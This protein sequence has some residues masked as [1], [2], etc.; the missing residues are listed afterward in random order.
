M[1]CYK[2]LT[3]NDRMKIEKMNDEGLKV[4]EIADRLRVHRSTIYREL[5]R[6]SCKQISTHLVELQKYCS[7]VAQKRYEANLA[8]KGVQIK[9][10]RHHDFALYLEKKIA[11]EKY[12]PAA[13]LASIKQNDL[14]F[15]VMICVRTLYNYIDHDVF[16]AI[17]NK[18]LPIKGKRKN[19]SYKRVKTQKRTIGESIEKRDKNIE[20]REE[21]GHFEMDTVKGTWASSYSLLVLTERKTRKEF[22][23]KIRHLAES[24]VEVLNDLER[25][26][27]DNF[28]KIFKTIT[29][30]NGTEFSYT[31]R[32]QTSILNPEEERTKLY[33]CHAYSSWERGS[34]ENANKLIRRHIEKGTDFDDISV[35]RVKYI[36]AWINQYP[37]AIFNYRCAEVL[38]QEELGKLGIKTK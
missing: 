13:A 25:Q 15:G 24:V 38:W 2:H 20:K 29:M 9:L 17:T 3:W 12:S 4:G 1:R 16:G 22:I 23:F 18:E 7:D 33:Y 10:A 28:G 6:G 35:E 34:N 5:K 11:E 32:L 19:K 8:S 30:D 27:G 31:K 37:R 26:W 21:F 14:D 36:E